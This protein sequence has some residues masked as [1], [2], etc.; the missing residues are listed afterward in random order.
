MMYR[1]IGRALSEAGR[2]DESP[3]DFL[4][5]FCLGNRE[6]KWVSGSAGGGD[7]GRAYDVCWTKVWHR[8][9]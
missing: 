9:V 5:F 4:A 1:Y 2:K 3:L 8:Q 6:T 7:K